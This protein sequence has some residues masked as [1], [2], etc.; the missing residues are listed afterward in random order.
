MLLTMAEERICSRII[1]LNAVKR[2][3]NLDWWSFIVYLH[4]GSIG[5]VADSFQL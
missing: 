3:I 2:Q 4:S 5:Q 1:T